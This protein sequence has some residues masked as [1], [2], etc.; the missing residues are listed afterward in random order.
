MSIYFLSKFF[1]C[2]SVFNIPHFL[3]F[4]PDPHGQGSFRPGSFLLADEAIIWISCFRS[5][6]CVCSPR[7]N[8]EFEKLV[9]IVPSSSLKRRIASF[10]YSTNGSRW[11]YARRRTDERVYSMSSR[12]SIHKR[13]IVRRRYVLKVGKK[14]SLSSSSFYARISSVTSSLK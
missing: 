3:Y 11:P 6:G 12:C 9:L 1:L 14:E 4:L 10:L 13:S 8:I 7:C 2:S 5:P